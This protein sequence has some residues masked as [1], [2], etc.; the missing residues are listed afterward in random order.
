MQKMHEKFNSK[1]SRHGSEL[2]R[3][4][5]GDS[6]A[7]GWDGQRFWAGAAFALRFELSAAVGP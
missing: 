1:D 4:G 7:L 6:L 3:A 2:L 5:A